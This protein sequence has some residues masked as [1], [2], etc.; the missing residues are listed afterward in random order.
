MKDFLKNVGATVVGLFLFSVIAT[1]IGIMGIIG[2]VASTE[3]TQTTSDNSVLVLK[4]DGIM[5]EQSSQNE[6]ANWFSDN[7]DGVQGLQETLDAI[8]KAKTNKDIKGIYMEG[9]SLAADMAQMQ[10][11]RDALVDFKKS[12]K[13]II[14]YGEAF[15]QGA[16]YVATTADKIY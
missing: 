11:M 5:E 1:V 9:G 3:A 2:M 14:A 10:E 7:E 8:K 13:W 12:G 6:I 4:L 15:S 16:Y